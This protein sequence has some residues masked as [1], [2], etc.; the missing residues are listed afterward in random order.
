MPSFG[1][2]DLEREYGG[3]GGAKRPSPF[4]FLEEH[5]LRMSVCR[6]K[7]DSCYGSHVAIAV[8]VLFGGVHALT[9]ASAQPYTPNI[10]GGG[11]TL[12]APTY[13]QDFNCYGMPLTNPPDPASDTFVP[14]E[15]LGGTA[16]PRAGTSLRQPAGYPIGCGYF[17]TTANQR[18]FKHLS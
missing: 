15:C 9:P 14:P 16:K 17:R 5:M 3:L 11:A 8:G 18:K 6:L 10:Q 4:Y 7:L 13:R 12:P 1:C 2:N